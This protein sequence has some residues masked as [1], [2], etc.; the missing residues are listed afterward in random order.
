MVRWATATRRPEGVAPP[1]S[2]Q[3]SR[4]GAFSQWRW[5]AAD[6]PSVGSWR[7]TERVC[8]S[9]PE[10]SS[11]SA[12]CRFPRCLRR[13]S[14]Y[15]PRTTARFSASRPGRRPPSLAN[16]AIQ[17][18]RR[19]VRGLE[20]S[21]AGAKYRGALWTT[22]RPFAARRRACRQ[23]RAVP[24]DLSLFSASASYF[25]HPTRRSSPC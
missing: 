18:A 15:V 22:P 1:L 24:L 19:G 3:N 6:H 23:P 5:L 10:P 12:L 2:R 11:A 25:D 14:R 21:R 16:R 4:S 7:V 9:A 8:S 17:N 13:S 20:A